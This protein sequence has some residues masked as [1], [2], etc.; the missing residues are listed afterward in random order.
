M[1][2]VQDSDDE[3]EEEFPH[4]IFEKPLQQEEVGIVIAGFDFPTK[5]FT[6][7]SF[8]DRSMVVIMTNAILVNQLLHTKMQVK[9]EEIIQLALLQIRWFI[10]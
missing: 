2:G 10:T 6:A 7:L 4:V 5:F 9:M 3:S 1:I 8:H